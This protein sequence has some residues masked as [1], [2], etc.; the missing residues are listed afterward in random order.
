MGHGNTGSDPVPPPRHRT[1]EGRPGTG[2]GGKAFQLPF[3]VVLLSVLCT[4]LTGLYAKLQACCCR[5][6]GLTVMISSHISDRHQEIISVWCKF[7][8]SS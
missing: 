2:A 5:T 6:G 8:F 4:D 7:S 1:S 3:P